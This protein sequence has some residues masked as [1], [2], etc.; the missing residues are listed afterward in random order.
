MPV[1]YWKQG[2]APEPCYSVKK[3]AALKMNNGSQE[4][5]AKTYLKLNLKLSCE[6]KGR[7]EGSYRTFS[8]Y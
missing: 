6:N 3:P 4:T 7:K 5:K 2:P 8:T 1:E